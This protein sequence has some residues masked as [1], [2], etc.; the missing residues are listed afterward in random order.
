MQNQLK[1]VLIFVQNIGSK[2]CNIRNYILAFIDQ[3]A[4][5]WSFY[6]ILEILQTTILTCLKKLKD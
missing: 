4:S 1:D 5:T 3:W 2:S 6:N